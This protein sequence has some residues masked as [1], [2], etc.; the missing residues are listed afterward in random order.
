MGRNKEHVAS[1]S[2]TIGLKELAF[3]SEESDRLEMKQSKLL[4]KY[5]RT[6]MLDHIEKE[7]LVHG[8]ITWCT[9][10]GDHRE[11]VKAP[12]KNWLC[13]VCGDDKT[14]QIV[15]MFPSHQI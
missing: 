7:K 3:L 9:K 4:T 8:P 14:A 1:K 2:F 13:T 15:H 6:I 11:F 5:I 12:P 10:C